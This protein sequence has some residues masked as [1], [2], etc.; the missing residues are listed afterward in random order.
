MAT[1]ESVTYPAPAHAPAAPVVDL[2]VRALTVAR[3][4]QEALSSGGLTL[5]DK[6]RGVFEAELGG[7]IANLED[8]SP[9]AAVAYQSALPASWLEDRWQLVCG[10]TVGD[11]AWRPAFAVAPDAAQRSIGGY[12]VTY[13][14][15][16]PGMG[17]AVQ[18]QAS[19]GSNSFGSGTSWQA[20]YGEPDVLLG[21]ERVRAARAAL[22]NDRYS[23]VTSPR[24]GIGSSKELAKEF[25]AATRQELYHLSNDMLNSQWLFT[26]EFYAVLNRAYR[27]VER[28]GEQLKFQME[29][30]FAKVPGGSTIEWTEGA[31]ISLGSGNIAVVV[32]HLAVL[33]LW[34][35]HGPALGTIG[36]QAISYEGAE[37]ALR[38]RGISDLADAPE[39]PAAKPRRGFLGFGAPAAPNPPTLDELAQKMSIL[40]PQLTRYWLAQQHIGVLRQTALERWSYRR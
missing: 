16:R 5:S 18:M 17:V 7:V 23:L 15:S 32:Q 38:E 4:T 25:K 21:S 34:L 31:N 19:L 40:S 11:A 27:E 39:A 26:N 24:D 12:V 14:R 37:Q 10:T 2:R 28:D 22:L 20:S 3:L 35:I 29:V 9:S 13:C 36:M 30:L 8:A 33:L 1:G 6:V